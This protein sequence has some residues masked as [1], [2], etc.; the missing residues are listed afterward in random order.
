MEYLYC[1]LL[2]LHSSVRVSKKRGHRQKQDTPVMLLLCFGCVFGF[3]FSKNQET[4]EIEAKKRDKFQT[5]RYGYE[6]IAM[7][8]ISTLS[9]TLL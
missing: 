2:R 7:K 6:K 9:T 1:Y 8:K 3:S 4:K 5:S